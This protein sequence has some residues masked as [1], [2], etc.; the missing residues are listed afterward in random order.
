M[1]ITWTHE[2]QAGFLHHCVALWGS[3]SVNG[4]Q[5]LPRHGLGQNVTGRKSAA[6]SGSW[7]AASKGATAF[8][9]RELQQD[10]AYAEVHR[11]QFYCELTANGEPRNQKMHKEDT[12][13]A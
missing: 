11:I 10:E 7:P 13:I 9:F 12:I 2:V 8:V 4:C 5:W 6:K 3:D 1:A